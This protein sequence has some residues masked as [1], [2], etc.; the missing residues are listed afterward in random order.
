M[1]RGITRKRLTGAL[2]SATVALVLSACGSSSGEDANTLLK[3]TFGGSHTVTSGNVTV[4]LMV[5]PSGS[6]TLN[7]PISLSFGGPFQSRGK[8]Q[9]PASNFNI[10]VT[11]SGR[12]GSI[13]ILST[14]TNG[15]VTLQ[16]TSYQL[17]ASTFQKLE[18]S[19]AQVASPP[20]GGSNGGSL[21]RLG[22]DPLHWLIKPAVVG[23]ESVGGADTTHIRAG[24][25]VAAL[26]A[27]VNTMLQKASSLGVPATTKLPSISDATRARIASE[28]KNPTVDVWTGSGDKTI[29]RL[30]LWLTVPVTGQ[31]SSALGGLSS[32]QIAVSLQYAELNQPQTIQAPATVR[33]FSE[34]TTQLQSFLAG[35]QSAT[36]GGSSTSAAA[37]SLQRY[38]QCVQAA[39]QN[40]AKMQ[41]CAALLSK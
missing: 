27:D 41:R 13:G 22:I 25:D 10:S 14:G 16:G 40:T 35:V 37:T 5:N 18:S 26:L 33:P 7:G 1:S 2:L 6:R 29:R 24:V 17:P 34:F 15:Y 4:S 32:A 19:F 23:H 3:Q 31:I 8:G 21:S 12:S 39:H 36:S 9:L 28:V 11:A 20:G 30:S 38:T